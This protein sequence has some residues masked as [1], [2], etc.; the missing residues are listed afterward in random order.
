MFDANAAA[1]SLVSNLRN[2]VG[3]IPGTKAWREHRANINRVLAVMRGLLQEVHDRCCA[4]LKFIGKPCPCSPGN[5]LFWM[6]SCQTRDISLA[7]GGRH[8]RRMRALQRT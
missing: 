1:Q 5:I 4:H 7:A 3:W 8:R 6:Q 2:P